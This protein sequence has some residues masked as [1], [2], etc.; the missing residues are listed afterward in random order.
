MKRSDEQLV[1]DILDAIDAIARHRKNGPLESE[2]VMDAVRM[3][4]IEIG[5]A[6]KGLSSQFKSRTPE[7]GWRQVA[8][9]RDRLAHRYF[10][11]E[12]DIIRGTVE[13]DLAV[14]AMALKTAT[15]EETG[16]K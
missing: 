11:K 2:I 7:I 1:G 12:I 3:R 13:N 8:G 9:M 4:L 14:L 6:A 15:R 16:E 10:E 5:E